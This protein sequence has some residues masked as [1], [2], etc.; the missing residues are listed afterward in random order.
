MANLL[1]FA[2][3][4]TYKK[5]SANN[6]GKYDQLAFEVENKELSDLLGVALLQDLQTNPATASNLLLLNGDT[7]TD[8]NG[9]TIKHRGVRFVLAYLN[10]SRYIGESM[11]N[12]TFTGFVVKTRPDSEQISEGYIK[13]LQLENRSIA[14]KEFEIIKE[15]LDSKTDIFT[16]WSCTSK[17]KPFTPRLTGVRKTIK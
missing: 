2:Q 3:Q 17:R 8:C 7:F 15:Y 12:D 6:G 5:I 13:R 9:N 1:T 11:I 10:F 16:L 14:L 4:Q